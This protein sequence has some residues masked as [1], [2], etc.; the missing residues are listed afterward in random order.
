MTT[1]HGCMRAAFERGLLNSRDAAGYPKA[2]L[3]REVIVDA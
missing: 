2:G 1:A 3:G